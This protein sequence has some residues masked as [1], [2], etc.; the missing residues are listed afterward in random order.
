M[1]CDSESDETNYPL[2]GSAT[3]SPPTTEIPKLPLKSPVRC[4]RHQA[5][6]FT[7]NA[8]NCSQKNLSLSDFS[9]STLDL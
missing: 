8:P 9:L 4:T 7:R 5:H 6:L 1:N 2:R 3:G